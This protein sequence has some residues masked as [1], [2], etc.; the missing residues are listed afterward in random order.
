MD[1]KKGCIA[2]LLVNLV[3]V[4]AGKNRI[5]PQ[6]TFAIFQ[7]EVDPRQACSDATGYDEKSRVHGVL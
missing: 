2:E 3:G 6:L 1:R 7:P 4:Y 5:R